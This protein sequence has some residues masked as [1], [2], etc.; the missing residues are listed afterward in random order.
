[1]HIPLGFASIHVMI[2]YNGL[3]H[4]FGLIFPIGKP[5]CNSP[6]IWHSCKNI[7]DTTTVSTLNICNEIEDHL[8]FQCQMGFSSSSD[9]PEPSSCFLGSA[10]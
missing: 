3:I 6:I 7:A 1:M 9:S 2:R 4:P 10:I 5:A 8:A